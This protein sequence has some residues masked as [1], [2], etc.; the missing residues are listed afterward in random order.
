MCCVQRKLI[1]TLEKSQMSFLK[2]VKKV[3]EMAQNESVEC[4]MVVVC[5]GGLIKTYDICA[6][7]VL[8]SRA[9]KKKSVTFGDRNHEYAAEEKSPSSKSDYSDED[10]IDFDDALAALDPDDRRSYAKRYSQL[11]GKQKQPNAQR[12]TTAGG[13]DVR[14]VYDKVCV[15]E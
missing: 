15:G 7:E 3:K 6:P 5:A 9:N 1:F 8:F 2:S 14:A 11:V 10:S 13:G 4:K 12:K